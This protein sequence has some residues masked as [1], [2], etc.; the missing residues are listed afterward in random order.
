MQQQLTL[1]LNLEEANL[2]LEALGSMPYGKVYAIVGNIQQQ[3]Q[4]QLQ[5]SVDN[6]QQVKANGAAGKTSSETEITEPL[7]S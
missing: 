6:P 2:I 5:N 4:K 1:N 3:A 7:V